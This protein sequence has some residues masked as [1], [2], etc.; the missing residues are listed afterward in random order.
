MSKL[1]LLK[2]WQ[3]KLG[4]DPSNQKYNVEA[5]IELAGYY[6]NNSFGGG[7]TQSLVEQMPGY[8]TSLVGLWLLGY[9]MVANEGA[10]NNQIVKDWSGFG[11][12]GLRGNST[13]PNTSSPAGVS[14]DGGDFVQVAYDASMATANKGDVSFGVVSNRQG[15][16][17]GPNRWFLNQNGRARSFR[18]S[19]STFM[20]AIGPLAEIITTSNATAQEHWMMA[21]DGSANRLT[22]Y[23]SGV[24]RSTAVDTDYNG[25]P[26][27]Q[28]LFIGSFNSTGSRFIGDIYAAYLY[29]ADM[30]TEAAAINTKINEI[31]ATL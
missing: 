24:Q 30:S 10:A 12:D 13:T 16:S 4:I 7:S 2:S 25:N 31:L 29:T 19:D 15:N 27:G 18:I 8:G 1:D 20:A 22:L 17:V 6:T 14:F 21:G 23:E 28:D 26:S 3:S 9:D 11:N 5:L